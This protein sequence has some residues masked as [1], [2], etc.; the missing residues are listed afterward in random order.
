[1]A[2]EKLV[3]GNFLGKLL[4]GSFEVA[5]GSVEEAVSEN[6][7]LF[8]GEDETQVRVIGTYPDHIV[9]VNKDGEFYRCEWKIEGDAAVLSGIHQ[10]DV[11]I[12]EGE[13]QRSAIRSRYKE[14]VSAILEC[15]TEEAEEKLKELL[16]LVNS[17]VPMTAESVEKVFV[18]STSA[19]SN[20][21]WIRSVRDNAG[22]LREWVGSEAR[23]DY[24]RVM[25]EHLTSD[26]VEESVADA[27]RSDVVSAIRNVQSF[28]AD[29]NVQTAPARMVVESVNGS[30]ENRE[31]VSDLVL[32]TEGFTEALDDMS[33]IVEDVIAVAEDGCVKC[34]ARLHDGIAT[35][36]DE[37]SIAAAF[38]SKMA[39]RFESESNE[40]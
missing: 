16:D 40:N 2:T 36:M 6:A 28:L 17:G 32:F 14:A 33:S 26:S 38:T 1:M 8:G 7:G 11:P 30:A 23:A 31:W 12:V 4:S 39:R 27:S 21:D 18:E 35:Q 29:L 13:V 5:M 10:I 34:L 22:K 9:V 37:W 3:D 20:A 25:F 24:P 19:F 15:K